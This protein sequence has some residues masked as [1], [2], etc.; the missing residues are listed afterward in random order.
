MH[1]VRELP[2]PRLPLVTER[3]RLRAHRAEDTAALQRIY[4]RPDVVRFLLDDPWTAADARE[5]VA[6]RVPKT[7]LDGGTGAL[8]LV[9]EHRNTVIGDVLLWLTDPGQRVAE[10]GWV[11]DPDHGGHGF[12]AEAVREVLR[13]GFEDHGLHRVVAR[14]DARN[15]ASAKLAR[16]VGMTQEA[17]LRQD[18]WSKGEWTDTLIFAVLD[19]DRP[20]TAGASV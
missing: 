7:D 19:C 20:G 18:W 10:I 13:L 6:E 9:V 3:L 4:A 5:R 8:A 16:R 14:M 1:Y 17:H 2:G 12:A 11:L 15:E